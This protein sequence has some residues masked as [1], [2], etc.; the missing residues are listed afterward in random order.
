MPRLLLSPGRFQ[1]MRS[2]LTERWPK[3]RFSFLSRDYLDNRRA[4][5]K[6]ERFSL[7]G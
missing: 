7:L 3:G 2:E 5:V 1:R 6:G 4:M